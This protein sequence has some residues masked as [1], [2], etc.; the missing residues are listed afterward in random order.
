MVIQ[1]DT[2]ERADEDFKLALVV[3][4]VR[5]ARI[6]SVNTFY[7][8]HGAFAHLQFLAVVFAKTGGEVVTRHFNFLSIKEFHEILLKGVVVH[9]LEVVEI[10]LA[11]R[12]KRGVHP[13]HEI[14]VSTE[15]NRL[16]STRLELN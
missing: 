10:V 15:G 3:H 2:G 16:E 11:V 8:K 13:V 6:Q 1:T 12:Q 7:Q 4:F 5:K 14:I 9:G